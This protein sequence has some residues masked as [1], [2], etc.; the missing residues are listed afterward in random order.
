MSKIVESRDQGL[1]PQFSLYVAIPLI[2][3]TVFA[4]W[5]AWMFIHWLIG[6]GWSKY[7]LAICMVGA[8]LL[9]IVLAKPIWRAKVAHDLHKQ[10][11]MRMDAQRN[12]LEVQAQ[13]LQ[14][15]AARGFNT[16]V[17]NSITGDVINVINPASLAPA[18]R[19]TNNYL[20]AQ[21][22]DDGEEEEIEQPTV[23]EIVAQIPRNS[24][25]IGLGRSLSTGKLLFVNLLKKHIKVIGAS[26]MGKSSMSGALMR[27]MTETHAPSHLQI[28][29]LD[30]ENMTCHLFENLPH[31]ATHRVDGQD[32]RLVARSHEEVLQYLGYLIDIL[33]YRYTL[34][35]KQVKLL[36]LIVVYLEE[37]LALKDYFK[38][39]MNAKIEGAKEDY[40][41][42]TFCIKEIARRGLKVR[43]QLLA[44]AQCDYRDE[45]L[46]EA[47]INIKNG[48]SFS[49]KVTAAQA[50]GFMQTDL[51]QQNSEDSEPGQFVCEMSEVNDLGLAPWFD[52]EQLLI[53]WEEEQERLEE[54]SI[55]YR[56]PYL[57]A[58]NGQSTDFQSGE[59][60]EDLGQSHQMV[61]EQIP[62]DFW[63]G[64]VSEE[65]TVGSGQG[66][67]RSEV[68]RTN[69]NNLLGE[70]LPGSTSQTSQTSDD[71]KYK[72]SESEKVL[73][74][75]L[76][77][78]Y[79]NIDRVLGHMKRGARWHKHA[80]ETLKEAG[81]L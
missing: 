15:N 75:E 4:L 6:D 43:M 51:L 29:L 60:R 56:K 66:L 49:V 40:A 8:A 48:L 13:A 3:V 80:S 19:T 67:D 22:T 52:L 33:N 70:R 62:L 42:L 78:A 28:A 24:Y 34:S 38:S 58:T 79:K 45:D 81:L 68:S 65:V 50:A 16:E 53:E 39:R 73:V 76:Y 54:G 57:I 2:L 17:S 55:E 7:W 11:M 25:T 9:L 74:V 26:Q 46:V 31:V 14:L 41:N 23:E 47:W 63:E 72:F 30:L 21:K 71:G 37:M 20:D 12:I 59:D 5:L 69:G 35:K 64:E 61:V 77:K 44:C 10:D 36:P 1:S 32:I 18:S 27:I